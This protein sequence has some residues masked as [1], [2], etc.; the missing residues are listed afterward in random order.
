MK[1]G[2]IVVNT[3]RG[4][5]VDQAAL[6]EGLRDGRL[7]GA[8]LD[9][10]ETEPPD[11]DDELLRLPN[12]VVTPHVGAYSEEAITTLQEHAAS[13]VVDVLSGVRPPH[14]ADPSVWRNLRGRV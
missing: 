1:H 5:V 6:L 3:A 2:A 14:L 12:V 9:V 8:G 10:L 11:A 4:A 13:S 7:G